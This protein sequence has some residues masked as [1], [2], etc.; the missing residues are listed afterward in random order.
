MI[1]IVVSDMVDAIPSPE[2]DLNASVSRYMPHGGQY[3][4]IEKWSFR[5]VSVRVRTVDL[6]TVE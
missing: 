3:L 1:C 5:S 6:L 2:C 4:R